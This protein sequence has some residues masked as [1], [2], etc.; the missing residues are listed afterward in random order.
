[1]C[2]LSHH[3]LKRGKKCPLHNLKQRFA[4]YI[5]LQ[6]N[7][8]IITGGEWFEGEIKSIKIYTRN[9]FQHSLNI[10]AQQNIFCLP[11]PP[12]I[13]RLFLRKK[14]ATYA[15][16]AASQREKP[17][18]IWHAGQRARTHAQTLKLRTV[19][20]T[21]RKEVW[22]FVTE[23]IYCRPCLGPAVEAT[24]NFPLI[25]AGV[26]AARKSGYRTITRESQMPTSLVFKKK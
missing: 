20:C 14:T 2:G 17:S 5:Y 23:L 18:C 11:I 8:K 22:L 1:M 7:F 15:F 21:R 25:N 10:N 19:L 4:L 6:R 26:S 13:F 9:R 24:L 3:H 12:I 16:E